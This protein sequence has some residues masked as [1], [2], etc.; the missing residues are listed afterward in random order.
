MRS[1]FLFDD[2]H[3]GARFADARKDRVDVSDDDGREP[4]ADLVEEQHAR[5]GHQRAADC[6]HLLLAT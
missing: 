1:L 3:G 5:V 6:D 4:E 2:D